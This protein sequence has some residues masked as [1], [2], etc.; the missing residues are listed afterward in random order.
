MKIPSTKMRFYD[1]GGIGR[2]L[3]RFYYI[4]PKDFE[5][6]ILRQTLIPY[7]A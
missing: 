3:F 5:E 1:G 7:V 6:R 4:N 2:D